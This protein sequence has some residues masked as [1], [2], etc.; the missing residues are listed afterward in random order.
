MATTKKAAAKKVTAPPAPPSSPPAAPPVTKAAG[1]APPPSTPRAPLTPHATRV[2]KA[3]AVFDRLTDGWKLER[4]ANGWN[5]TDPTGAHGFS[6]ATD[7][8]EHDIDEAIKNIGA[9]VLPIDGRR[10][11]HRVDGTTVE[12]DP[13]LVPT[14]TD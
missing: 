2:P 9:T 8:A 13:S 7:S 4:T 12:L 1:E 10:V 11:L 5:V 3:V 6:A 14:I